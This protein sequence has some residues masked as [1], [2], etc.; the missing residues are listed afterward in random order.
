[1]KNKKILSAV[2]ALTMLLCSVQIGL[3]GIAGAVGFDSSLLSYM[4]ANHDY[5]R[6][7]RYTE[8]TYANYTSVL[9]QVTAVSTNGSATAEE[10]ANA[11]AD[12]AAAEAALTYRA[13]AYTSKLNIR[14]PLTAN[15]GET[16]TL[17]FKDALG[18]ALTDVAVAVKG[19][20]AAAVVL[21]EDGF[22]AA[23]ITVTA[24]T[25]ATVSATI[26]YTYDGREYT[27]TVTILV[28]AQGADVADKNALGAVYLRE[29][30]K[31][32]QSSDYSGGFQT[33]T[34]VLAAVATTFANPSSTQSKVDRA[35]DNMALAAG[36][37]VS[38]LADYSEIYA[39]LAQINEMNS[40]NYN[41]FDAVNKA[42]ALV[43]YNLPIEQ[44]EYVNLMA[45]QI[46][47]AVDALTL[48]IARYTVVCVAQDGTQ[49][50]SNR[51]DGTRTYVVRVV[52]PVH[53]GYAPDVEYQAITLDKDETI[54][55]FTYT[56]VTYYAYFNPN[57]GTCET[58]TK[59]LS[60][61]AEYGEL[62]VP[63]KPGYAF[64]GWFSSPSGGEQIF[65]ETIVTLNYVEQLYAHWSD[66]ESYT[67]NFDCGDGDPCE[68]IT[69]AYG[70]TLT[71]PDPY[72]HGFM[73]TGWFYDR[74]CT[75]PFNSA[76][77][78]DL[79]DDGAEVT[80]YPNWVV[81]VYNVTLNPGENGTVSS[82]SYRVTYGATYGIIPEPSLEGHTFAGWYTAPD[83]TGKLV[84][85]S[86]T[87][88]LDVEHTLY[89]HYT[90]N[91][92]TLYFDMDGGKEIEPI[93][94]DYGTKVV[95]TNLPEKDYYLFGG[96]TLDNKPFELDTMPA[97]NVTIKAVWTL[98]TLC[99][100][101]LEPYKTVDGV[102]IPAKNLIA[103]ET[104]DVR[105]SIRTNYPVGQGIFAILFD[106]N[107]FSTAT[108]VLSTSVLKNASSVYLKSLSTSGGTLSGSLNY[109]ANSWKAAFA[110]DPTFD[111]NDWQ[112]ARIQT[113]AFATTSVPQIIAQKDFVFTLRL[114][115]KSPL[116]AGYT[117]GA[118]RIDPHMCR[119]TVNTNTAR[120]PTCIAMQ[121]FNADKDN[122]S[123]ADTI[124]LVPDCTNAILDV[125]VLSPNS[126]L[127]G[128]TG[129]TTVVDY[130]EGYV[131]GLAQ[132]LTLEKFA[133]DYA[134]IVGSGTIECAD[135]VLHTGS[136]IK[137]MYN[138]VCR[139]Q[140]TVI[141]FGDID[142]NG[143]ADG[144]DSYYLNLIASGM[145]SADVLTDAQKMAADPNHDGL[146]NADDVT[147]L[148]D[149][150]LLK[151]IVA[152]TIPA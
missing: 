47:T 124:N 54:V 144:T 87:V 114:K 116:G 15:N 4:I 119:T 23:D 21:G 97:G 29:M 39:L 33:Y 62:P 82:T 146:I 138:D 132:E 141:I 50:S 67:I 56:P 57:G 118:I 45:E 143:T 41:S 102:T 109:S 18:S 88:E 20:T 53:P 13:A 59:Q 63:T 40:D 32:R 44:Q 74:G 51:Y 136:V 91:S 120:Y 42:V 113:S 61:D 26:T 105:V 55:T 117:S 125:P 95:L 78:P 11:A 37:L 80:L 107:V 35:V 69:A 3:G 135:T 25:G 16:V 6:E 12:L 104:I 28:A 96:W 38:A 72:L 5:F 30:A 76:T 19:G 27:S 17:K 86:T 1:M 77:M 85:S 81:K 9:A 46:R 36:S 150:G 43:E 64:L 131:Y 49:L 152:Q 7:D 110:D 149:S 100:Y 111:S 73:S 99:E 133:S 129:S 10:I 83:E 139:A 84:E 130:T 90:V 140:Y 48:K 127:A 145:V 126:E 92:Y 66:I 108:T 22:Y 106:K 79:G 60:Y 93:T 65:A 115:V 8:A 2:M 75:Q 70:T 142:S 98:N 58:R 112:C 123:T 134:Q 68:P 128:K 71:L 52:A 14:L 122:Y 151:A 34:S 89:A 31:N 103:G 24:E 147:L 101:F 121:K 137:V 94:Q 148:A